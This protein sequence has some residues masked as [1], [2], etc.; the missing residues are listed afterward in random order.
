MASCHPVRC[1]GAPDNPYQSTASASLLLRVRTWKYVKVCCAKCWPLQYYVLFCCRFGL[2][3]I[4]SLLYCVPAALYM[5]ARH[6]PA[7]VEAA[8][9]A[10]RGL[11]GAPSL[12]L[13]G[14]LFYHLYN[15]LSYMVLNQGL[16]P[17]TFSVGNTGKRVAVIVASVAYFANPVSPMNWIGSALAVLGACLYSLSL[18]R[19]Y[20]NHQR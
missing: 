14:G 6:W 17:E 2:I 18:T 16:S 9:V 8:K 3:S 12:L 10:S 13:V 11:L 1:Q 15:Q 20:A 19:R 4:A 7:A 5:E